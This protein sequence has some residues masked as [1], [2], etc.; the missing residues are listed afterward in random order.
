MIFRLCYENC[1]IMWNLF[2]I[3]C[4]RSYTLCQ[5]AVVDEGCEDLVA[6]FESA[7]E[8]AGDFRDSDPLAVANR[9]FTDRDPLFHGFE[10]HLDCPSEGFVLHVQSKKLRIPNCSKGTQVCIAHAI[11]ALYQE[12]GEPIAEACLR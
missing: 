9:D 12:T 5:K 7:G 2:K 3:P 6:S 8:G 4:M 1:E 10:L 11:E